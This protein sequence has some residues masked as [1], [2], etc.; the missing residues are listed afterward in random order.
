MTD[1]KRSNWYY[2][3]MGSPVGPISG[4]ELRKLANNGT[5]SIDTLVRRD[6]SDWVSAFNVKGLFEPKTTSEFEEEKVVFEE[7]KPSPRFLLS[8]GDIPYPYEPIDLVFAFGNSA[9]GLFRNVQPMDAYR[10][11]SALLSEDAVAIGANAVI[12]IHFEIRNAVAKGILDTYSVF[13]VYAYGTAVKAVD[14]TDWPL[15]S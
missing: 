3:V 5:V 2:Q 9:E 6:D 4:S 1:P 15:D 11:A 12:Y 14:V 7:R 13:E 10:L 8:T